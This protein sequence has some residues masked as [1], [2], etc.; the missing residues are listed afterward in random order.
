MQKRKQI[1]HDIYDYLKEQG[2]ELNQSQLGFLSEK[3]RE[4][5]LAQIEHSDKRV[6][7]HII[8]NTKIDS[9][10]NKAKS[11]PQTPTIKV[12]VETLKLV[13]NWLNS[14]GE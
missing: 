11:L 13:L 12:Q 9:Y 2:F 8:T 1:R 6:S 10:I 14:D 4:H 3:I 7:Q 5:S